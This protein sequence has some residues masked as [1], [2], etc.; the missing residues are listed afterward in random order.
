MAQ[1]LEL[2]PLVGAAVVVGECGARVSRVVAEDNVYCVLLGPSGLVRLAPVEAAAHNDVEVESDEPQ[3]VHA[4]VGAVVGALADAA[5]DAAVDAAAVDAAA[6]AVEEKDS[7]RH[8]VVEQPL[9]G[10]RVAA[11]VL[12]LV[13][14]GS[15]A[16]AA[17]AVTGMV[18][19]HPETQ[20]PLLVV[21]ELAEAEGMARHFLETVDNDGEGKAREYL[22]GRPKQFLAVDAVAEAAVDD[23]ERHSFAEAVEDVVVED[24]V[25]E[26]VVVENVVVENV[27]VGVAAD[28]VVFAV[29]DN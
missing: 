2:T 18:Q 16:L 29:V 27:V 28:F 9:D 5:V 12:E 6:A 23:K 15:G 17:Y 19:H 21:D 4:V 1:P 24:V 13:E 25:V 3:L 7:V 14:E 26:N 20:K 22:G 8:R 10:G 11:V